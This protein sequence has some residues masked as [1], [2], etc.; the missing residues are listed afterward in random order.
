MK[1]QFNPFL[2][3]FVNVWSTCMRKRLNWFFFFNVCTW[4]ISSIHAL[5]TN[6]I[7]KKKKKFIKNVLSYFLLWANYLKLEFHL[8]IQ[9]IQI[10]D[11]CSKFYIAFKMCLKL[12][13]TKLS[14]FFFFC[15]KETIK[16]TA[17]FKYNLK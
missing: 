1:S 8:L 14:I 13:S 10:L 5:T 16:I 6:L 3:Y 7:I 17:H 4:F 9:K 11:K 12:L 15:K 2:M